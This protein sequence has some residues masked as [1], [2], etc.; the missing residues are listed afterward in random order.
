MLKSQDIT[1]DVSLN[2]E[3]AYQAVL[4][5]DYD[6]VFMDCQMPVM[7]GYE[8]TEKIRKAEAGKKHTKNI[9][10]TSNAIEGDRERCLKIG[11]D[12]YINKPNIEIMFKMIAEMTAHTSRRYRNFNKQTIYQNK[13]VTFKSRTFILI[14]LI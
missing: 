13:R 14:K 9:A 7:D 10:V 12:G 4:K 8:A 6:L 3:E 1:C 5:G 11:M 2:G